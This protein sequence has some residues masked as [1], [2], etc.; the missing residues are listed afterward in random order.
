MKFSFRKFLRKTVTTFAIASILA[1]NTIPVYATSSGSGGSGGSGSSGPSEAEGI[2]TSLY[3]ASTALTAYINA[4]VGANG[5]DK[6]SGESDSGASGAM[7][8]V[9]EVKETDPGTAGAF[10]GYGD[11]KKGFYPYISSS[12]SKAVTTTSYT[13]LLGLEDDVNSGVSNS[14]NIYAYARYGRL[15]NQLGL[16]DTAIDGQTGVDRSVFGLVLEGGNLVS[17]AVPQIFSMF[18]KILQTMNPFNFLVNTNVTTTSSKQIDSNG[19]EYYVNNGGGNLDGGLI[20]MDSGNVLYPIAKE[21]SDIY[22]RVQ[23]IGLFTILPLLLAFLLWNILMTRSAHKGRSI[24]TFLQRAFFIVLGIPMLA[25]FYTSTLNQVNLV[26]QNS[27]ATSQMISATFVDFENWVKHSRLAP[28]ASGFTSTGVTS[29]ARSGDGS[30]GDNDGASS[31]GSPSS[32]TIRTLRGKVFNINKSVGMAI[33]ENPIGESDNVSAGMW[34]TNLGA[35]GQLAYKDYGVS[36]SAI[37]KSDDILKRYHDGSRYTASAFETAVNSIMRKEYGEELGNTSSGD[38]QASQQGKIYQMWSAVDTSSDWLELETDD[39]EAIFKGTS[40]DLDESVKDWTGAVWNVFSNSG[41]KANLT[42]LNSDITY[43]N[44]NDASSVQNLD[45]INPAIK[46]YGLSTMSMYNFLASEFTESSIQTYSSANASSNYVKATHYSTNLVGSGGIRFAYALNCI[47][48]ILCIGLMGLYYGFAMTVSNI[49]RGLHLLI[50]I[51]GAMVGFLRSIAQVIVYV[52]TMIMEVLV[53][54]FLYAFVNQLV[55]M[56]A[57]IIEKP[58]TEAIGGVGAMGT[59]NPM[60][61]LLYN[62]NFAFI[63]GLLFVTF[64]IIFGT[65]EVFKHRRAILVAYEYVWCKIFLFVTFVENK[66]TV[67]RWIAH[68]DSLYIFDN[69]DVVKDMR[70]VWADSNLPSFQLN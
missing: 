25:I 18:L 46:G 50:S 6:N 45:A 27:P 47:A 7:H 54:I 28:P 22:N 17:S 49:K 5:Y 3:D 26:V 57:T 68:R 69:L 10:V 2:G 70:K 42:G 37:N 53:T 48:V 62:S 23:S 52:F 59:T 31:A 56:F 15:L 16:D 35:G 13:A 64:T 38:G 4:V 39:K 21:M 12:N 44:A 14:G 58:L 1:V 34:D 32:D 24:L 67:E 8:S 65:Y 61:E 66:A 11:V 63:F 43:S 40:G 55:V 33:G 20:K 30:G 51:P 41:L 9:S 19:N 60:F 29:S 36:T